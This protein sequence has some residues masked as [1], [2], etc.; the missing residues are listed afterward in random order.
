MGE[1][2]IK[3]Y[4]EIVNKLISENQNNAKFD[5]KYDELKM[6]INNNYKKKRSIIRKELYS[7]LEELKSFSKHRVTNLLLDKSL[8]PFIYDQKASMTGLNFMKYFSTAI[9][10]TIGVK[11]ISKKRGLSITKMMERGK[12]QNVLIRK[13]ETYN[14]M[15]ND[16]DVLH[17]KYRGLIE[18]FE[19]YLLELPALNSIINKALT[20]EDRRTSDKIWELYKENQQNIIKL[21]TQKEFERTIEIV[22]KNPNLFHLLFHFW[23]EIASRNNLYYESGKR[24]GK[25]NDSKIIIWILNLSGKKYA[26][27]KS[28]EFRKIQKRWNAFKNKTK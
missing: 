3:D 18:A 25:P 6:F 16:N 9:R 20:E 8:F 11:R 2:E 28:K 7:R 22:T 17:K 12:N 1:I 27:Y 24:Y 15:N 5:E 4:E 19:K 21:F 26:T 23:D 13:L 14:I 10:K